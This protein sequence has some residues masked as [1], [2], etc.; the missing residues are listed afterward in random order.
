MSR[1]TPNRKAALLDDIRDGLRDRAAEMRAH[2][3]SE[4]EMREWERD[5]SRGRRYLCRAPGLRLARRNQRAGV[6]S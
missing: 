6:S 2:D 4:D 5:Y 3:I 1:W